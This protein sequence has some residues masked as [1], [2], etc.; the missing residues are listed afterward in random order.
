MKRNNKRDVRMSAL[1]FLFMKALVNSLFHSASVANEGVVVTC[2]RL[3]GM[4]NNT[5][6]LVHVA[7][8]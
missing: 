7:R 3:S 8:W 6:E 1:R 5:G 2:M 4:D